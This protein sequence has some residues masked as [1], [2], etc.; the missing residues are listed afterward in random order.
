MIHPNWP[1]PTSSTTAAHQLIGDR[2]WRS[3]GLIRTVADFP[4]T[5]GQNRIALCESWQ[6]KFG[7]AKCSPLSRPVGNQLLQT[8]FNQKQISRSAVNW[9]R[10]RFTS[11]RKYFEMFVTIK[12][13]SVNGC[14]PACWLFVLV[15][16][17]SQSFYS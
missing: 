17:N 11:T 13:H 5:T 14:R 3:V 8:A 7:G 6:K 10:E 2:L 15:V 12:L 9:D 1:Q 16:K 4:R